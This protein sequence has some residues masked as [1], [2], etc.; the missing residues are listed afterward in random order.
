MTGEMAGDAH[1]AQLV[2]SAAAGSALSWTWH[3]SARA[4]AARRR[5]EL[6][7]NGADACTAR[8]PSASSQARSSWLSSR[9]NPAMSASRRFAQMPSVHSSSTSP[10]CSS[11]PAADRHLG[12]RRVAAETALDEVAH[13]MSRQLFLGDLAFAQQQLDVAV[14][15]RARCT[16]CRGADGTRGCRRCGPRY[17]APSW[18]R[19]MAVVA[20]GRV[21]MLWPLPSFATSS[22]ARLSD[23]CRKPSGSNIGSEVWWN[24][25]SRLLSAVSA[26][27]LPSECP[28]MPSMTI[29]S[30][31]LSV[32]ATVT[33]SWL[34]S[35][36][37]TR[38]RSAYSIRKRGLRP[39]GLSAATLARYGH[40]AGRGALYTA[41]APA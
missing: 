11:V 21:S 38:L 39:G 19:Q 6:S 14:I 30:A 20:R 10:G 12:N 18:T 23:M 33:R 7:L 4:S 5:C 26:A 2:G 40:A 31:A 3:R 32:A 17:A 35:R 1:G 41:H 13:R 16:S 36:S 29:S 34:S 8:R 28:P 37:P 9:K 24:E 27:R 22:C 15:A 25:S